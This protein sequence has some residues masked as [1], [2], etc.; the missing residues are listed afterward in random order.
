MITPQHQEEDL[1]KAYVQAVTAKAGF[2]LSLKREHDY[3]VDGS[4]HQVSYVK[5]NRQETGFCLDFQ[6][7][8]S[9]N[10]SEDDYSIKYDLDVRAYNYLCT[11]STSRHSTPMLLFVL[12]L[13]KEPAYWLKVSHRLLVMRKSCYWTHITGPPTTNSTTTRISIPKI[14]LLTPVALLD[15]FNKIENG[16][17]LS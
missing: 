7:K 12:A 1:S 5:G 10:V 15:I 8:S 17:S 4:I 13:P 11:R 16:E 9:I 14:N 2:N 6:L 3:T